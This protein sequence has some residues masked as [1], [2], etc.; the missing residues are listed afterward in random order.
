MAMNVGDT[1]CY[2]CFP[3][4]ELI[5][6]RDTCCR[7]T[8]STDTAVVCGFRRY[9]V[10]NFVTV[11]SVIYFFHILRVSKNRIFVI[12]NRYRLIDRNSSIAVNIGDCPCNSCSSQWIQFIQRFAI[13]SDTYR[14]AHYAT[15]ICR[16]SRN[17]NS[18]STD[19][20]ISIYVFVTVC[21]DNRLLNIVNSHCK[22]TTGCVVVYIGYNIVNGGFPFVECI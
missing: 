16:G 6:S 1:P 3:N 22:A 18:S 17:C 11:S 8:S 19:T 20:R 7:Y 14:I 12:S 10:N 5:F 9:Q 2:C 4:R 21:C 13:A 15:I